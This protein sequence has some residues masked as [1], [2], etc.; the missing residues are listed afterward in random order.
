MQVAMEEMTKDKLLEACKARF[1]ADG[2]YT[3][4]ADILVAI[5][6]YQWLDM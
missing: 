1:E 2:I 5:N 4:V 3:F 6:P